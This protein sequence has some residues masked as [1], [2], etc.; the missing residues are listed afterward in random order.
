MEITLPYSGK[1]VVLKEYIPHGIASKFQQTMFRGVKTN[2]GA[3]NPDKADLIEAYGEKRIKEIDKLP[4]NEYESALR[5]LK[6]EY[7]TKQMEL[8][9]AG[10]SNM[11]EANMVKI[12]GM[13]IQLDGK[14]P[15]KEDIE[16]LAEPDYHAIVEA[17]L[18]IE[19]RP[20]ESKS[21]M[22]YGTISKE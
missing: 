4:G 2:L 7:V 14:E 17:I 12:L 8:D 16:E 5:K 15:K 19:N 18:E 1:K 22:E 10:L 21:S 11:E 20:L 3:L 9:D 6:S 13:V